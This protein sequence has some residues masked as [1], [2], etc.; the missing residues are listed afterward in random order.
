MVIV[1]TN[2]KGGV[3]K[4]T[5]ASHMAIFLHDTGAKVALLDADEQRSSSSWVSEAEPAIEVWV[6]TT[7]ET[8]AEAVNELRPQFDYVI[9]DA[10]GRIEDESR[11]LMLLADLAVF[12][13]TPSILDLRSVA[14]AVDVLKYARTINNGRPDAIL[15]LNRIKKRDTI[16]KELAAV[17]PSLGLRVCNSSVR[18]LQAFRNAAQQG[19]VVTRLGTSA[20]EAAKDIHAV[21]S[22]V[23]M[24]GRQKVANE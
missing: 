24:Q 7:P 13:V 20:K 14:Q 1:F 23:L 11:T 4:S 6:A 8:I 12:P 3:G 15:V 5:L 16:S 19:T 22:E 10:P 9:A 18:D 2:T 21:F 17:A